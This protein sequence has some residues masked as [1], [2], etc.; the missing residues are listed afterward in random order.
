MVEP[1][2]IGVQIKTAEK[3]TATNGIIRH[4]GDQIIL[5]AEDP[6]IEIQFNYVPMMEFLYSV[7]K[8]QKKIK[9]KRM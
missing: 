7:E 8:E 1:H 6:K 3:K 2:T 9:I 4:D 5:R